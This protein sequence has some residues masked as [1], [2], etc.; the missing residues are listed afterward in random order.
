VELYAAVGHRAVATDPGDKRFRPLKDTE[1]FI[2]QNR[3]CLL[4][5]GLSGAGCSGRIQKVPAPR[6]QNGSRRVPA[7]DEIGQGWLEFRSLECEVVP[8]ICQPPEKV[9]ERR[10]E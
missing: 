1:P 2:T 6:V 7:E 5:G 9:G 10:S 8:A 3:V 4:D